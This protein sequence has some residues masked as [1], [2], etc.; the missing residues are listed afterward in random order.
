MVGWGGGGGVLLRASSK[1][2]R[3]VMTRASS[4]WGCSAVGFSALPRTYIVTKQ[5]WLFL[6]ILLTRLFTL[7]GFPQVTKNI[8]FIRPPFSNVA[9]LWS[10]QD[11]AELHSF[12][13]S[14]SDMLLSSSSS[15][16]Q[17]SVS[18]SFWA[19]ALTLSKSHVLGAMGALLEQMLGLLVLFA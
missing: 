17:I 5:T 16:P 19:T 1:S 6:Y 12:C 3:C 15:Y 13:S 8:S 2:C 7:Q 10:L 9:Q 14:R 4:S 18:A 11:F